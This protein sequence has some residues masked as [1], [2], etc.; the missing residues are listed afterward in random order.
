MLDIS[1]CR[2]KLFASLQANLSQMFP[3]DLLE[4]KVI[5]NGLNPE[6]LMEIKLTTKARQ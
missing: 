5:S 1:Y 3:D 6:L 4:S 2:Q